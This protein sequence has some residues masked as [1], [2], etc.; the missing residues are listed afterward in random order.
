MNSSKIENYPVAPGIT[1]PEFGRILQK[2]AEDLGAEIEFERA[3]K[4]AEKDGHKIV[5]TEDDEYETRAVIL[6]SGTEPRRLELENE[7][8]LIG[9]GVSYCATCDG[10]FFKG[11]T[12]AVNGGGNSALHEAIYLSGLAKKVYLIHRRDE[13]RGG[14]DLVEKAKARKNIEIVLNATIESLHGDNKLESITIKQGSTEKTIKLDGLFV[15]IGREPK[16]KNLMP[17][18]D[19]DDGGFIEADESCVTNVDGIFVAGD[20][21]SKDVRQLVTATGDGAIAATAALH[22]LEKA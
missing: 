1:G 12:V 2:Q 15:S 5:S 11:K 21:R 6:A 10:N 9:H 4:I 17:E 16:A 8:K 13:F 20:V 19:L 7:E 14:I 22:Y 3:L 18:L